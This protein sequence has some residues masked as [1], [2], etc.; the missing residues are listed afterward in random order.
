MVDSWPH[1]SATSAITITNLLIDVSRQV[2]SAMKSAAQLRQ[3]LLYLVA[4]FMLNES[5]WCTIL[6]TNCQETPLLI[7]SSLRDLLQCYWNSP[8]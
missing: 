6:P 8:K 5:E 4:Y 7:T 2:W 1:V 3:C